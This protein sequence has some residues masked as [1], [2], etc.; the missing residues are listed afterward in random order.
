MLRQRRTSGG[1]HGI[2]MTKKEVA[3]LMLD[4]CDYKT[5][6]NLE[7]VRLLDPA[8]GDGVYIISALERLHDSAV[9]FGFDFRKSLTNIRTYEIKKE[10]AMSLKLRIE[11]KISEFGIFNYDASS[12]VLNDD[13]LRAETDSGF[14]IVVGNPP[15][16][17][18]DNI[19]LVDR[20]YYRRKFS[21]FNHRADVYIT[22]FERGLDL[23]STSGRLCYICPDRWLRNQFGASLRNYI[24]RKF[25]I[26]I[27]L[28]LDGTNP[29]EEDV[30]G[31]PMIILITRESQP[32][33]RYYAVRS[34][35]N[36]HDIALEF[37][38]MPTSNP[39][40]PKIIPKNELGDIWH[41]EEELDY[42]LKGM[43]S[44]EEQ[45]FKIGIGVA[46][47]ADSVFI[48]KGLQ[49]LVEKE[50]LLPIVL[51]RD[52]VAG[53]IK[54]SGHYVINPFDQGK[55]G[56]LI[57]L[58][59]YPRAKK[60][61]KQNERRLRGRHVAKKNPLHWYRTIDRIEPSLLMKPK[62]LIPDIKKRQVIAFD[63]GAYYPHHNLYYV[64][65]SN[66]DDLKVLGAIMMSDLFTQ[67]INR[68]SVKMHG[69]FVRHQAQN[70][71]KILLP[72]IRSISP[73]MKNELKELF[74][75]GAIN[76]IDKLIKKLS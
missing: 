30:L 75:R 70:L 34:L 25:S 6:A 47:G 49:G 39:L 43:K 57:D 37:A 21:L 33:T 64:T 29:F 55:L 54:W 8:G 32:I 68:V 69:G 67:Q 9:R 53:K 72:D 14:D 2:V 65:D 41:F 52:V 4:L 1:A 12:I 5:T 11:E 61:F 58:E 60:Y 74:D 13:F 73:D 31:Y 3:D 10:I 38:G 22:F 50:L 46:T 76:Q 17:R 16:I 20:K 66:S 56:N 18:Y 51:S 71:R 23:L 24:S 28:N 40:T 42:K 59:A 63:P 26:P 15:Y 62:L 48:G 45:G 7:K 36:L 35:A 44:I 27:V 19:P